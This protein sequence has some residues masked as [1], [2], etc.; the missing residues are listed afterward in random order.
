MAKGTWQADILYSLLR[1][2]VVASPTRFLRGNAKR[3]ITRYHLSFE[4]LLSRMKANGYYI[5][6]CPGPMG[7]E[8]GASYRCLNFDR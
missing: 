7:G 6:R 4:H 3:Y 1:G 8:W 2:D 5:M